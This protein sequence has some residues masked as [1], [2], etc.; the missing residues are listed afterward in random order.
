MTACARKA[1]ELLDSA[2]TH[3][4]TV[5]YSWSSRI[6]GFPAKQFPCFLI[7]ALRGHVNLMGKSALWRQVSEMMALGGVIR[8]TF[9]VD[10]AVTY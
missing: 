6:W 2:R 1:T 8:T 9:T 7:A 3:H 5:Y 10:A 4:Q